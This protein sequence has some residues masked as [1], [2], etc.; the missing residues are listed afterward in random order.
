MLTR[1]LGTLTG[2]AALVAGV[3]GATAPASAAPGPNPAPLA[4]VALLPLDDR[5]V[6]LVDP[7]DTGALAGIQVDTPPRAAL[8]RFTTPGDPA[9]VGQWLLNQRD[10][11]AY[12]VSTS[13]L[14]YGGLIA[15]RTPSMSETDAMAHIQ[16]LRQVHADHPD[17]PLYV[18]DTI[19]RLALTGLTVD[20]TDYAN[21][22]RQW[23]ILYDQVVNLG[24]DQYRAHLD[25][26]RA[27]IPD[28][29]IADYLAARKRNHD[30]NEQM[31]RWVA[32]G[33]I[34]N[35]VL[36]EDDTAP[37]G[38][39]R[40]ERVQL[41]ELAASLGVTDRVQIFPGA[42]EIDALLVARY[43][44]NR[45]H[46]HP[47]VQ[48][49]YGGVNGNEWTAPLE[50]I[51]FADNITRHL[52]ALGLTPAN[53]AD[54]H[55]LVNTPAATGADHGANLDALVGRA[56]D[57]IDH[58]AGVIVDDPLIVNKADHDLVA[59]MRDRLPL[60]ELLGYSGWN[61]AG[62]SLGLSLAEG[63][64]RY[65]MLHATASAPDYGIT[66]ATAMA[67]ADAHVAYLL[68]RFVIDDPWKNEV[69]PAA[70][71]Y[72]RAQGWNAYNL[73]DA[74]WATMNQWVADRLIPVTRDW[75]D[76][77]FAG[78]DVLI[79]TFQGRTVRTSVAS[80]D[81]VSVTQPWPR[82]FET[83]LHVATTLRPGVGA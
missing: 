71:A 62:N 51:P 57:L 21:L 78:R 32:D 28:Q 75:F 53:N 2:V 38:L 83:E 30:V 23:A 13:M 7:V 43:A 4:H 64:A 80:L 15:S 67:A 66:Q 41:Q 79:G 24:M 45:L 44:L 6:N 25:Q 72:V 26:V 37:Y 73:T 40:A 50:D 76:G 8:G 5:P 56:K 65:A 31:V 12:V 19:Q 10:A 58:G 74:Q 33:T 61:T 77:S 14:A 42:D 9:A 34:N 69:Q 3:A 18:F 68:K 82:L 1:T 63:L 39:E 47:S 49:E 35:L 81:S 17:R 59:R 16:P 60:P 29:V 70:M 52:A 27:Q 46:V 36:G 22:V 48:V 11:D 20:G 55:L 54:V